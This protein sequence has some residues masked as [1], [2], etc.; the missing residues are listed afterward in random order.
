MTSNST[1]SPFSKS[2]PVPSPAEEE[3]P[4]GTPS[5]PFKTDPAKHRRQ[6]RFPFGEELKIRCWTA[7]ALAA[8]WLLGKTTRKRYVGA[9]DL[10][11]H[12]QRGEQV[13]LTFWHSRILLMAFPYRAY[14]GQK[15][16]IMNSIHRDGEIITRVIKR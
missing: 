8:L 5:P 16:Y 10:L 3:Q 15:A 1:I 7:L 9:E 13:I 11:A 14:R 6:R 2:A 4:P 12:W